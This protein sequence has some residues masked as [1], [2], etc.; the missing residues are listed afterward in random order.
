MEIKALPLGAIGTNCY[1][2][3]GEKAAIV[4]D[5]GFPNDEAVKFLKD[6]REK[7]RLIILT[8]AH[9]DH[10]GFALELSKAT[11]TKIAI[12]EKDNP[13]LSDSS[14]NLSTLFNVYM[15]PFSADIL[16]KDGEKLSL[17]DI[18][19][20]IIETPGH[21]VGGI[22]LLSDKILFS[23]DTLFF[24]SVGRT[25]LPGGDLKTLINSIKRLF[26][27]ADDTK[28]YPGHGKTTTIAHE[29]KFNPYVNL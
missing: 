1:L 12:G 24:Q 10:I 4:I 9:F 2:I 3:L 26:E 18:T 5:P 19:F 29:K 11:D 27:L 23:G 20:K 16:L 28:V 13:A 21:T 7:E 15:E 6:N 22:C 8:H 25:D 14:L 17:G